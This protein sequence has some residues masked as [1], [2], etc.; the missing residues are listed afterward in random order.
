MRC[1]ILCKWF[2]MVNSRTTTINMPRLMSLLRTI[3]Q[4]KQ[5]DWIYFPLIKKSSIKFSGNYYLPASELQLLLLGLEN[6]G[7]NMQRFRLRLHFGF[8]LFNNDMLRRVK[9]ISPFLCYS[10]AFGGLQ[11]SY[12]FKGHF[13]KSNLLF[14][15]QGQEPVRWK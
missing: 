11:Y 12:I 15:G 3:Y 4:I 10:I 6:L 2:H 5:R 9:T 1:K 13:W 8:N 14:H 7:Q